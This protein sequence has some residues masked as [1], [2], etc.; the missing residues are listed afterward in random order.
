[1][2]GADENF[3]YLSQFSIKYKLIES[4]KVFIQLIQLKAYSELNIHIYDRQSVNILNLN[5]CVGAVN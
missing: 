2:T 5:H 3:R 4:T 1:M